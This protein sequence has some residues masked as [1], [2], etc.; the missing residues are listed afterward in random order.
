MAKKFSKILLVTAAISSAAATA[1][2]FYLH[3]REK[4]VRIDEEDDYDDFSEDSEKES[5]GSRNYVP[6]NPE[7][8]EHGPGT[9]A[10]SAQDDGTKESS[11]KDDPEEDTPV[12]PQ[13][14]SSFT[15]L[16]EQVAQAAEKAEETVEKFFDEDD[17]PA[18][19]QGEA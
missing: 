10:A 2:Y 15:P 12:Q 13:E 8:A 6:L 19:P 4:D 9:E 3:K 18:A 14:K 17:D 7:A 5:E 16:A 11:G 1:V